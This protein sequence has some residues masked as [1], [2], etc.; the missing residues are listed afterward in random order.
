M[1]D[2]TSD[3]D[4]ELF[5]DSVEAHNDNI[6]LDEV[7]TPGNSKR[8]CSLAELSPLESQDPKKKPSRT[9]SCSVVSGPSKVTKDHFR[10]ISPIILLVSEL[11]LQ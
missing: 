2:D 3:S 6:M 11:S 7:V 10:I 5:E 9:K 8:K 4:E 1:F